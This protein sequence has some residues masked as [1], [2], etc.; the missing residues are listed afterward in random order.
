MT[1]RIPTTREAMRKRPRQSRSRATTAAIL[2]ATAH[3]LAAKGWNALTTNEI[4]EVAGAS[5]GSLYQ[6]FPNKRAIVDAM[7]ERHCEQL[8]ATVRG[9]KSVVEL[10]DGLIALHRSEPR[11]HRVLLEQAPRSKDASFEAEYQRAWEEQLRA[12]VPALAPAMPARILGS[13]LASAIHT[14][15]EDGTLD[16]ARE[17][18]IAL[19]AGFL[20]RLRRR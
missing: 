15:A 20:T 12:H 19:V 2:D 10:V 3:I 7:H 13:A 14:A 16:V 8:V 4:A 9:A 18:L 5:I 1:T 6:Y 11:H 17:D